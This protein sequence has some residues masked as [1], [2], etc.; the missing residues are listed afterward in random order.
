MGEEQEGFV[1]HQPAPCQA[2]THPLRLKNNK[3]Y[4]T[5]A[6]NR[7][8]R[9]GFEPWDM[10]M[11]KYHRKCI[12]NEERKKLTR[13]LFGYF[14]LRFTFLPTSLCQFNRNPLLKKINAITE[15][16]SSGIRKSSSVWFYLFFSTLLHLQPFQIPQCLKMLRLNPWPFQHRHWQSDALTSSNHYIFEITNYIWDALK[17]KL[18][19]RD[20]RKCKSYGKVT[21]YVC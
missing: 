3:L 18:L 14:Q 17:I 10:K 4:K 16:V 13:W 8:S 5:K 20:G 15:I 11:Y 19:L 6:S 9:H 1:I 2:F 21:K 7:E 12:Q